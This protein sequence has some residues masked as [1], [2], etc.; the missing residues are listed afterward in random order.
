MKKMKKFL[1]LLIAMAM[2][3]SMGMTV[4]ASGEGTGGGEGEGGGSGEGQETTA[5]ATGTITIELPT[6]NQAPTAAVTYKIYKVFD[7]TVDA[8]DNTKVSYTLCSGDS[9]S[10]AMKAAGF[11]VTNGKVSGPTSLSDAAIAAIAAYV[12]EADIVDTVTSSVGDATVTSNVLDYGYYYITTSTG[13]VVTIDSNNNTPTVKDKN[14][15]P[16][17]EKSAGTEYDKDSLKAIAQ[18]GTDQ[19]FTAQITKTNGSTNVKFTDT[20]TNM[21]YNA[22]LKVTVGG[23]EVSP[24]NSTYTVTG[25]AGATTFE[26]TFV[27]S[28]IAGLEDNTVITLNYTGHV[29]SDALSVDPAKNQATITFGDGQSDTSD[30]VEVYNA[31]ISVN[32][33]DGNGKPLA[34]AKFKLKNAIDG[35]A[36]KGKY[37]AGLSASG[38]A[39]WT[40]DG[41]EVEAVEITDAETGDKSYTA[42]FKGLGAGGYSLEESTVPSGYNPADPQT[43]T[44]AADDF[45]ATNLEQ[46]ANVTN[47]SGSELPSTGGIGTTIF[48]I[49][50]GILVVGAGVVLI[51]RRRMD[52]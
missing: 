35:S 17:V 1:A 48:Y 18:A 15:L 41:I 37:Y 7:A 6:D 22:D 32:K 11:T 30:T 40:N 24:G 39:F 38:A 21:T 47:N 5:P 14:I 8:T 45:T 44:V 12:T 36:D 13:V 9:L 10:A 25:A 23:T 33:K 28:Y 26:V 52:A 46:T 42:V 2:V 43:I 27:N 49:I 31:K 34:G 51:T 16:K 19:P 4:F 29:T 20:F 3:L 50:G